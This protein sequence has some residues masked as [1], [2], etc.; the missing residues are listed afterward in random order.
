MKKNQNIGRNIYY[1]WIK[2]YY[3]TIL[4]GISSTDNMI[5]SMHSKIIVDKPTA[6]FIYLSLADPHPYAF[7]L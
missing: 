1:R 6:Y 3:K 4:K 2:G 5:D 7:S